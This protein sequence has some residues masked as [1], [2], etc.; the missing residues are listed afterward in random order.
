MPAEWGESPVEDGDILRVRIVLCIA[1]ADVMGDC[2]PGR[3]FSISCT[4]FLR[5]NGKSS[6]D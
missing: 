3:V 6:L 1:V 4:S 5:F 2:A